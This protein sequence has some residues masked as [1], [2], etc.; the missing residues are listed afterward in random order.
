MV[1]TISKTI[2]V[3]VKSPPVFGKL[4]KEAR[5][6]ENK[7]LNIL[8]YSVSGTLT[9]GESSFEYKFEN[10][11]HTVDGTAYASLGAAVAGVGATGFDGEVTLTA[12]LGLSICRFGG[13]GG[14]GGGGAAAAGGAA[15]GGAEGGDAPAEE[16]EPEKE[17]EPEEVDL[18]G[19]MD[20]FGGGDADY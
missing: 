10:Y 7:G 1:Q 11:S 12:D 14:G 13:G 4:A 20:M 17:E 16:A 2:E 5:D 19:G 6:E 18:G 3:N 8:K 15:A 9:D